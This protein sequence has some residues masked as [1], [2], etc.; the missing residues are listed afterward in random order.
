M[1]RKVIWIGLGIGVILLLL[2]QSFGKAVNEVSRNTYGDGNRKETFWVTVEGVLEREEVTL[3]IPERSYP[4]A[5]VQKIFAEVI[6]ELDEVILGDN[7]SKDHVTQNLYFPA[8]LDDYPVQI[9]WETDRYD[10]VDFS[11][12]IMEDELSQ[13]GTLV[14]VRGILTYQTYEA[15]YITNIC[16]FPK[17]QTESETWLTEVTEAFQEQE[18]RTKEEKVIALPSTV[19]GKNIIWEKKPDYRVFAVLGVG[20]F[21][22]WCW[23]IQKKQ[24]LKQVEERKRQQMKRDYPEIVSTFA[25]LL[26]TGMTVK[27]TWNKIVRIYEEEIKPEKNRFAYEEMCLT[28]RE[29]KGGISELEAYERFGKR[30]N[31]GCY[32]KFSMLL[33]QNLRKGSK[34]LTELLKV[35]SVQALEQRKNLAKKRG[36]EASAKLMI[37]MFI[38]FAV[39]LLMIMVP[40]FLSIQL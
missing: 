13:E 10:V 37:P 32:T 36:E 20:V 24:D 8:E 15:M 26:G 40:A 3:E 38:M 31:V 17:E 16:V 1:K 25:L 28:S 33:A 23:K 2:G 9:I 4:Y 11:G 30:C 5:E 18:G 21:A 35:E 12:K 14:E 19:A 34:G 22:V 29:M 27:N 39:V 6:E 7:K